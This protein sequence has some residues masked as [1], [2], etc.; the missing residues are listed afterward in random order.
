MAKK[1]KNTEKPQTEK[2]GKSG[3]SFP[4]FKENDFRETMT[5]FLVSGIIAVA[6]EEIRLE[7]LLAKK[8]AAFGSYLLASLCKRVN[9]A[10]VKIWA[11]KDQNFG[12]FGFIAMACG[13]PVVA[14]VY[15]G[16][17]VCVRPLADILSAA[18]ARHP[19]ET[20][21]LKHEATVWLN[22]HNDRLKFGTAYT[23]DENDA[24]REVYEKVLR[25]RE[26]AQNLRRTL[27]KIERSVA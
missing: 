9:G 7:L 1:S 27:K 8:A 14:F 10:W 20:T 19:V 2:V 11:F 5:H 15:D 3:F 16:K 26:V 23:K 6:G 22:N 24:N 4:G 25:D 13:E 21:R 12:G 17:V 18:S